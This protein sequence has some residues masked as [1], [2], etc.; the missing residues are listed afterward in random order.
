MPAQLFS[1][2]GLD[3]NVEVVT[4]E[5]VMEWLAP[6]HHCMCLHFQR[7]GVT[8]WQAGLARPLHCRQASLR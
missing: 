5:R 2:R 3:A 4:P 6:R 7:F 8:E 1:W